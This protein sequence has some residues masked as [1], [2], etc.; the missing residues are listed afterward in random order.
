MIVNK[1]I[2]TNLIYRLYT[3][4]I[5]NKK[6]ILIFDIHISFTYFLNCNAYIIH[7]VKLKIFNLVFLKHCLLIWYMYIL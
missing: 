5:V 1:C 7:R 3:A 4:D 6:C 2:A